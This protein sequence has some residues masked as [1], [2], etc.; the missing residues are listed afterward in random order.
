MHTNRSVTVSQ[1]I[2]GAIIYPESLTGF[3]NQTTDLIVSNT[4]KPVGKRMG[5]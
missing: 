5:V 2:P 3:I 1:T 4:L